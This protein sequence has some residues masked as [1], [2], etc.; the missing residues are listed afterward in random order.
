VYLGGEV[1]VLWRSGVVVRS[2]VPSWIPVSA[3]GALLDRSLTDGKLE[4][5]ETQTQNF[6]MKPLR[7]GEK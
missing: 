4:I 3:A 1:F 6:G 7:D 5:D 2:A